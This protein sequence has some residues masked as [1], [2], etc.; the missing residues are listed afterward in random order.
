MQKKSDDF[1]VQEAMRLARSPAGQQLLALLQQKNSPMLQKAMEEAAAG[2]YSAVQKTMA[3]ALAN[4]E[5]QQL[6]SRMRGDQ[7]G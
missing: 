4:P 3:A 7:N 1:S 2:D 6:L 5:V